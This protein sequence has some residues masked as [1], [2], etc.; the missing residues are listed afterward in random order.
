MEKPV[1][2]P[3][4]P[5]FTPPASTP[6]QT[7]SPV[8]E[9][10]PVSST[11]S[12]SPKKKLLFIFIIVVVLFLLG[13]GFVVFFQAQERETA[14]SSSMPAVVDEGGRDSFEGAS[15][16]T[17]LWDA[18]STQGKARIEQVNGR[19]EIEIP[20]GVTQYTSGGVNWKENI[21]GDFEAMVDMSLVRGGVNRGSDVGFIF[22]DMSEAWDNQLSM[23]L[24]KEI[25]GSFSLRAVRSVDS[26]VS[27]LGSNSY[28]RSGP[29]TVRIVRSA[30]K[31]NFAVKEG[32]DFVTIGGAISDFY[33]G[34]GKITLHVN[35]YPLGFSSVVSIFDNFSVKPI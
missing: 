18:W 16:D 15:L 26:V 25:D 31:V 1:T 12:Q 4:Q 32:S 22:R 9:P 20:T 17:D 27:D 21:S 10:A 14:S 8:V 7:P 29:F 19:L 34:P 5:P 13:V 35:S 2:Q 6:P 23:F 30:G 33:L 3:S 28:P 24:R 11:A